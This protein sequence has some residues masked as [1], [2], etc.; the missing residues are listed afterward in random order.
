MSALLHRPLV[1]LLTV[2]IHALHDELRVP[3]ERFSVYRVLQMAVFL[4]KA[5]ALL[6]DI[7]P[8]IVSDAIEIAIAMQ[9]DLRELFRLF[10]GVS[11][12]PESEVLLDDRLL[13]EEVLLDIPGAMLVFAPRVVDPLLDPPLFRLLDPPSL[14]SPR[15][16]PLEDL[17][18]LPLLPEFPDLLP[19]LPDDPE[20][21]ES[22]LFEAAA[23]LDVSA[24]PAMMSLFAMARTT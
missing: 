19:V 9:P 1:K 5:K 12:L 7:G 17:E 20:L 13:F 18:L 6:E 16:L 24:L 11:L 15:D 3:I 14:E 8:F 4:P 2:E 23:E 21:L 22:V 10:E